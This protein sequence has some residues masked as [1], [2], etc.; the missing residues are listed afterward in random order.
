MPPQVVPTQRLSLTA[1]ATASQAGTATFNFPAP[2]TD[3]V[4][5]GTM[6]CLSAPVAAIFSGTVAGFPWA[7]W[8]G[9]SVGGPFQ[10]LPGEV[11]QITATGL[12]AGVTYAIQWLGR[13]DSLSVTAPSWPDTNSSP[14]STIS[15]APG[16]SFSVQLTGGASQAT[17][18]DASA[19]TVVL[20][21]T[22][23]AGQQYALHNANFT[24][25]SGATQ[26]Q[27]VGHSTAF[28]YAQAFSSADVFRPLEGQI[29][30]EA[31]DMVVTGGGGSV[32]LSYDLIPPPVSS[33][34]GT[35]PVVFQLSH[36]YSVIGALSAQ[37]LPPFFVPVI[38]GQTAVLEAVRCVLQSG[39]S[40]AAAIQQNGVNIPGLGAVSVTPTPTTTNPTNPVNLSNNDYLQVVLSSPV[41]VPTGLSVSIYVQYT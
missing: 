32:W 29:V 14:A 15:Q 5:H 4:W 1:T 31:L 38:S 6:T 36:S 8:G 16:T 35:T 24:L 33:G 37:T 10:A 9:P 34:G 41:G 12:T 19:G 17:A 30:A 25:G 40:I 22:P 39:T 7:S 27:I 26:I 20:L 21:A 28:V 23:P 3:L 2:A 18:T 11:V 13:S